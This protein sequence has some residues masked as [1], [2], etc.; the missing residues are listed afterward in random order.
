MVIDRF[1][2][3]RSIADDQSYLIAE[4]VCYT[5]VQAESAIVRI[6]PDDLSHREILSIYI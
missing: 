1:G 5:P 2:T 6:I 4:G 3:I